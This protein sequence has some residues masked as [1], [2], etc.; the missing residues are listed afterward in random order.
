MEESTN[1][2]VRIDSEKIEPKQIDDDM[3]FDKD[4]IE[5]ELNLKDFNI[6]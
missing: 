1:N 4:F 2:S 5:K 6:I 3:E